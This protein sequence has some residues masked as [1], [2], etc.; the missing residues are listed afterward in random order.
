VGAGPCG[1]MALPLPPPGTRDGRYCARPTCRRPTGSRCP[2]G[3][4]TSST[5]WPA[6]C[7]ASRS[8]RRRNGGAGSQAATAAR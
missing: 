7:S 8:C 3:R 6:S 5:R 2:T 4:T 1:E